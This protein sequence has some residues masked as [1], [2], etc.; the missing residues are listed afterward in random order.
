MSYTHYLIVNGIEQFRAIY[1]YD[2]AFRSDYRFETYNSSGYIYQPA[3]KSLLLKSRHKSDI[4]NI[5]LIY[6]T[7]AQEK[8]EAPS[9]EEEGAAE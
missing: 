1:I 9:D 5:R 7:A 4:E 3:T 6:T 8:A 2:I